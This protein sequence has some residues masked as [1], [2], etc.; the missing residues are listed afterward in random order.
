MEKRLNAIF[1]HPD[2]YTIVACLKDKVI[3]M[4]GFHI[5]LLYNADGIHIRIIALVTDKEYR[6]I[7]AGKKLMQAVE[8]YAE[9][10]GAA[11]IVFNSGN[12]AVRKN[13]HQFYIR[14]GFQAKSTG[15]VKN[16]S[17]V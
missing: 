7:G 10:L 6:G 5:G 12:R 9:Q 4:A 2:Y 15:F 1:L 14:L 13:A 3:G 11:A 16:L 17:S 8:H